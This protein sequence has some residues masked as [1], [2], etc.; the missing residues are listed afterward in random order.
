MGTSTFTMMPRGP[1]SQMDTSWSCG[2]RIIW[3]GVTA[4]LGVLALSLLIVAGHL[5]GCSCTDCQTLADVNEGCTAFFDGCKSPEFC[6]VNG[7]YGGKYGGDTQTAAAFMAELGVGIICAIC[8]AVFSCGIC[9]C[10]CFKGAAVDE[11]NQQPIPVVVAQP[12]MQ[13]AQPVPQAAPPPPP[14][15]QEQHAQKA[16]QAPVVS[17]ATDKRACCQFDSTFIISGIVS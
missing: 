10:A 11:Q 3:G 16:E 13:T 8:T 4:F 6:T 15:Q 14:P 12:V 9:P 5:G 1:V 2:S 17:D 7:Q